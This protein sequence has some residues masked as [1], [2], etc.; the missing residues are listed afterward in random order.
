MVCGGCGRCVGCGGGW[1]M[2][3]ILLTSLK[4]EVISNA[5]LTN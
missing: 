2:G 1:G 3:D 5:Q 4:K